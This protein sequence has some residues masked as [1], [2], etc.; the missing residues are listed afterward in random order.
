MKSITKNRL[1]FLSGGLL[2]AALISYLVSPGSQTQNILLIISSVIAGFPIA[3]KAFQSLRMKAFS[4]DLLVTVA[5]LGAMIIGEYTES[6]VVTFLFL[7]GDY[8]EGRTLRKTRSSLRSLINMAPIEATILKD[9]KR[10]TIPADEVE[11]GDTVIVQP[12]GRIPVDGTVI[13]GSAL[14][15]EAAFTGESVPVS[16]NT[17][18]P[19]FSSTISDNGYLEIAAEKVGEDTTFSKIIELVEEAQETKAETQKFME[20]F[21]KYYTPGI[22]ILAL[23]VWAITQD[24]YLALT[25]LVIACPGAL[26]I[27]VPVSIVAGIG[28]GAKNGILIKGGDKMEH[29]AK[30]NAIV[31]DKTGTLTKG[32]PE[33]TAINAIG[34]SEDELLTLAAEVEVV[35]EHHLG[36]TIV[37]KAEER[38]LSLRQQPN[39]TNIMKGHGLTARLADQEVYIGNSSGAKKLGILIDKEIST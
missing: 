5:V 32:K 17:G 4:I 25:F 34:I 29:L 24:V 7:F 26:V 27:S 3:V 36:K 8:L 21:A 38:G 6:A 2:V 15:N 12:G 1:T 10:I 18:D 35:S 19:V 13:S 33:I 31:F 23:F 16:K 9:G 39:E 30:V 28:N 37:K 22:I 20:R 14:I 11:K